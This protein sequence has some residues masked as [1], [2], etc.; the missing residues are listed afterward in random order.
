MKKSGPWGRGH[1][2]C[3]CSWGR[4]CFC[5]SGSSGKDGDPSVFLFLLV[6]SCILIVFK[7]ASRTLLCGAE[8]T[9]GED[10]HR[11]KFAGDEGK[12]DVGF[13]RVCL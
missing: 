3:T 13:A 6:N 9:S 10:A 7:N 11:E 1:H 12:V 4:A 8:T 5:S 2:G